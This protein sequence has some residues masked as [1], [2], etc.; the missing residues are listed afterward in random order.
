[1]ELKYILT[2]KGDFAIFTKLSNH[3]DVR[4][5][6]G[7]VVSAGFCHLVREEEDVEAHIKCYGRSVSLNL[8][9][10]PEDSDIINKKL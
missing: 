5:L 8:E 2:D 10:R 9:S 7:K 3:S 6:H 1:M 4:G